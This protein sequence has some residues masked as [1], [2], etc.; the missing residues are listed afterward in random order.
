MVPENSRSPL[1]QWYLRNGC[2]ARARAFRWYV[3][4]HSSQFKFEL[5]QHPLDLT[6]GRE[7][8]VAVLLNRLRETHRRLEIDEGEAGHDPVAVTDRRREAC[9]F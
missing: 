2:R 8:F 4:I 1:G 5:G 7:E 9:G 3:R 6:D